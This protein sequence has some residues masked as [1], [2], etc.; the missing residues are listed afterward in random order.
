MHEHYLEDESMSCTCV[1][2]VIKGKLS[3]VTQ[4]IKPT[5][6]IVPFFESACAWYWIIKVKAKQRDCVCMHVRPQWNCCLWNFTDL[7]ELSSPGQ[8]AALYLLFL[9]CLCPYIDCLSLGESPWTPTFGHK[10]VLSAWHFLI[11]LGKNISKGVINA[12][13]IEGRGF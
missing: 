3:K 7:T 8:L 5:V 12:S 1:L 2:S 11:N 4:C 13:T 10:Q 9:A 6:I